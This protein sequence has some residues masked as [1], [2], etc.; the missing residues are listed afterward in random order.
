[1]SKKANQTFRSGEIVHF[2][3]RLREAM[4]GESNS[5]FAKKCGLSETVIR[6]YLAGK[7]YPGIDKLPAIAEASGRSIEWLVTGEEP[8]D[9]RATTATQAELEQW[10]GMIRKSLSGH[11]LAAIVRAFQENGKKAL[12]GGKEAGMQAIPELSQSA[13]NTAI[14]FEALPEE[15]RRE[16][17]AKHGIAKQGGP[18]APEQEPHKTQKKAG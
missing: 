12:L 15:E 1:M 14:M 7:S 9:E 10:W 16:I 3:E 8:Q 2:G 5:A 18:V 13:I 11:E 4:D 17:L 6:N